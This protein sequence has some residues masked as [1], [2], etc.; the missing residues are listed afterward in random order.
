MSDTETA[1]ETVDIS[2][3]PPKNRAKKLHFNASEKQTILNIYKNE[4]QENDNKTVDEVV[5]KTANISGVSSS[6]VYRILREYR[7]NH[8]L[9]DPKKYPS[10]KK[11]N[12]AIDDFDRNAIRRIVHNFFFH[13][14]LPTVDKVLRVVNEDKDLPD[15][16]RST[17]YN[18]LKEMGF[19]YKK[20]GRNSLLLEKEEIVVWRREYLRKIKKFR[21][22][23]KKIY[24]LDETWVNAG[25]TKDKIWVDSSIQS[26]RQAFL[27]GLSTGLKN[28][29][30]R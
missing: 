14:E 20:R 3:T 13:N 22:E 29:S 12:D 19:Q 17:F 5:S 9:A 26:S 28:P 23:N 16:K 30:G 2:Y 10:R 7:A 21:E 8:S 18:L 4:M 25:H 15:F 6:S 24:Y 27:D 11:I 1:D